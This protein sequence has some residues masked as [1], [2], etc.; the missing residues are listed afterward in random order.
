MAPSLA[1]ENPWASL[2]MGHLLKGLGSLD[3][4]TERENTTLCGIMTIMEKKQLQVRTVT[5][6]YLTVTA[7]NTSGF[8]NS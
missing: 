5:A 2:K 1:L 3:K 8:G 4:S 6:I 7:T